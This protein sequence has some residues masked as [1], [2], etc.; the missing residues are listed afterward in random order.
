MMYDLFHHK[1]I[2]TTRLRYGRLSIESQ[3]TVATPRV[4]VVVLAWRRVVVFSH[5]PMIFALSRKRESI[6]S[7]MARCYIDIDNL[8]QPTHHPSSFIGAHFLPFDCR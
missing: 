4:M 3:S 2:I 5:I 1:P 8:S 7:H 6:F